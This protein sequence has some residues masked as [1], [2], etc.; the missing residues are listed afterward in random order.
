MQVFGRCLSFIQE[1]V[2]HVLVI[3]D[4][5]QREVNAQRG[6]T[7]SALTSVVSDDVMQSVAAAE[8]ADAVT[9][10]WSA[11]YMSRH[12]VSDSCLRSQHHHHH[13]RHHYHDQRHTLSLH[14][15][16]QL[17]YSTLLQQRHLQLQRH[18]HHG[19]HQLTMTSVMMQ[20]PV[21]LDS[22]QWSRDNVTYDA[23]SMHGRSSFLVFSHLFGPA[24]KANAAIVDIITH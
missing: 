5:L 10:P 7:L 9:W 4:S 15:A 13:G 6:D 16:S 8:S 21:T 1:Y 12:A 17:P 23:S 3:S 24:C 2:E 19:E 22:L 11:V 14:A 18:R 20:A